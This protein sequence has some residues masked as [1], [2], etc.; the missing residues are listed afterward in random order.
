MKDQILLPGAGLYKANLH[1]H[2]TASDGRQ[3][4][5]AHV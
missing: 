2:T 1:C 3:I 4:G 5:R